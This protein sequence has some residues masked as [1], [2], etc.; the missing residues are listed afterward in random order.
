MCTFSK[1]FVV[2]ISYTQSATIISNRSSNA[3]KF[4][5]GLLYGS[6][7]KNASCSICPRLVGECTVHVFLVLVKVIEAETVPVGLK[8]PYNRC[9]A[10]SHSEDIEQCVALMSPHIAE[11]DLVKVLKHVLGFTLLS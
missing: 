1:G 9:Q 3:R 10:H 2:T 8:A 11:D 7:W 4:R 6:H 5:L